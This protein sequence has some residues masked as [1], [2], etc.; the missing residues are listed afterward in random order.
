[1][2]SGTACRGSPGSC[3]ADGVFFASEGG[4]WAELNAAYYLSTICVAS[5]QTLEGDFGPCQP[6]G[7][8]FQSDAPWLLRRVD[9]FIQHQWASLT[10]LSS[11]SDKHT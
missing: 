4:F 2:D 6:A 10:M 7:G 1:M 11:Q 5:G 3:E 9:V 8:L